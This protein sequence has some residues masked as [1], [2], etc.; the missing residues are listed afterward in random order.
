ML[1]FVLLF[2]F[3]PFINLS[4]ATNNTSTNNIINN[5]NIIEKN[6]NTIIN[7]ENMTNDKSNTIQANEEKNTKIDNILKNTPILRD[8]SSST[9]ATKKITITKKWE[10]DDDSVRPDNVTI[11]LKKTSSILLSG[12][13]NSN[14]NTSPLEN[15]IKQ[16]AGDGSQNSNNANIKSIKYATKEEYD[17]K[18]SS[19]TSSNEIQASGEKTY[20]W[21][22]SS[23]TIYLYSEA[24]NIYLN[25][26]SGG[27]FR[28][29]T[30]L[31]DIS[32]L[33][34]LNTF[35]VTD[36]NRM[37]Q[38]TEKL[39]DLT[40]IANWNVSNVVNMNWIFGHTE[41]SKTMS[42]T[43]DSNS[44]GALTNWNTSNVRNFDQAFKACKNITSL[45]PLQNWDVSNVTNMHQMF[46]WTTGLKNDSAKY[47]ENWDVRRVSNFTN[48]FNNA[49]SSLQKP[50]FTLREP[51]NPENA[52]SSGRNI[53]SKKSCF[54]I[55]IINISWNSNTHY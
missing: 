25:N 23:S 10:N 52:W 37:F 16:I 41:T 30:N 40:P 50:I 28:K 2:N 48:M 54:S 12:S 26:D 22:D 11:H 53:Q 4:I 46:N 9:S 34:H 5:E 35:Y 1:L 15:K 36:M 29:M 31:T 55:N 44:L 21:F 14:H 32:G 47:I 39:T 24:D 42:I 17:A 19:L 51:N 43:S 18:K 45:E 3:Y 6:T 33:S 27:I 49:D 8:S 13:S 38:N 20:M 7:D